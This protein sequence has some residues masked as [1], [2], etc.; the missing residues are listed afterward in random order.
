[1]HRWEFVRAPSDVREHWRWRKTDHGKK[2]LLESLPFTLF[3]NCLADAREHGFDIAAH[4]F[5]LVDE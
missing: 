4:E 3:L 5:R 2:A 1:L